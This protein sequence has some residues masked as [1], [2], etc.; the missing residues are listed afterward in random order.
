MRRWFT[1][2]AFVG[3]AVTLCA[4]G[5]ASQDKKKDGGP[6]A[7]DGV[8]VDW[9]KPKGYEPGKVTAFWTWHEDGVWSMRTTGGAEKGKNH[10]FKG[11]IDVVG[12]EIVNMKG[13]KGEYGGKNVD[14]YVFTKTSVRFDFNTGPGED[15]LNFRVSPAATGLKFAVSIDGESAPKHVRVGKAGDHPS[16]AAFTAPAHPP[17]GPKK[18]DKKKSG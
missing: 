14:R 5:A 1:T 6:K 18:G 7:N 11:R 12:G 8:V 3:L 13:K 9:G 10:Q 17:A 15:G 16:E 2:A 4:G